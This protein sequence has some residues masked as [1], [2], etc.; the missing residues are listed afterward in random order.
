MRLDQNSESLPDQ[1]DS[2]EFDI[3]LPKEDITALRRHILASSGGFDDA[4][5][6]EQLAIDASTAF[7]SELITINFPSSD[8]INPVQIAFSLEQ[9]RLDGT[10]DLGVDRVINSDFIDYLE[11]IF[12]VNARINEIYEKTDEGSKKFKEESETLFGTDPIL[13]AL[14]SGLTELM[15]YHTLPGIEPNEIQPTI[16]KFERAIKAQKLILIAIN[17]QR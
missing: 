7:I 11:A 16:T 9:G 3:A 5:I 2:P 6:D 4:T 8:Q 1:V 15:A 14:N 17:Y 13:A 12:D 10:F